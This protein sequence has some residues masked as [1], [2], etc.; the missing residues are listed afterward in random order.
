[1]KHMKQL[2]RLSIELRQKT[3][4]WRGDKRFLFKQAH[5]FTMFQLLEV[6]M[7]HNPEFTGH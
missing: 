6:N 5:Y 4:Y 2:N 7:V 3:Q 1:M